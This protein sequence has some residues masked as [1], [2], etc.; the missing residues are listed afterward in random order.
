[1]TTPKTIKELEAALGEKWF[2][3]YESDPKD[4]WSNGKTVK[5][6]RIAGHYFCAKFTFA[7]KVS[8]IPLQ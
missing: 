4:K 1:M 6:L 7:D 3:D 8:R 5:R 2:V